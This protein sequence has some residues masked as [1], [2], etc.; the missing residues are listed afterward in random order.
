MCI[1]TFE[2]K[3]NKHYYCS[4]NCRQKAYRKV[5]DLYEPR[6]PMF[7]CPVCTMTVTKRR[8]TQKYCS[9]KCR[10]KNHKDK[11]LARN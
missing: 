5:H 11:K 1:N 2:P 3:R 4:N 6:K 9:N 10:Q 8:L 7:E